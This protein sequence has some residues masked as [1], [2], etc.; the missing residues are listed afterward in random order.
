MD[1]SLDFVVKFSKYC[2]KN[3]TYQHILVIVDRLTKCCLYKPLKTLQTI[4]F[5]DVIYQKIFA[6]YSF[7]LTIVNDQGNQMTSIL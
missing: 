1:L 4:E 2:H 7:S 3:R 6:M 5:I